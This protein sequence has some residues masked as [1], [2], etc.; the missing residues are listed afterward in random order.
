M[1]LKNKKEDFS[2]SLLGNLLAGKGTIREGEG[3]I[4]AGERAIIARLLMLP[5]P[6]TNFE[7]QK[8]YE[9]EP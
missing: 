7:I 3:K 9:N 5:I 8:Y 2:A 1:K 6:L 4:R